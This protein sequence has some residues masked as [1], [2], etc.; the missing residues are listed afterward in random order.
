MRVASC[1]EGRL[2]STLWMELCWLNPSRR[3]STLRILFRRELDSM[4]ALQGNCHVA[5]AALQPRG[6]SPRAEGQDRSPGLVQ[7][8][9]AEGDAACGLGA[10]AEAAQ[11]LPLWHPGNIRFLLGSRPRAPCWLPSHS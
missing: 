8:V 5:T 11:T 3:S 4:K 7:T 6:R 10:E 2:P 1:G 9:Q